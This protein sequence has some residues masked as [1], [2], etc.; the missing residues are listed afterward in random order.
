MHS[1]RS[2]RRARAPSP[3]WAPRSGRARSRS[4]PRCAKPSSRRTQAPARLSRRMGRES[5]SRTST[6]SRASA[7]RPSASAPSTAAISAPIQRRRGSFPTGAKSAAAAWARSSGSRAID[8]RHTCQTPLRYHQFAPMPKTKKAAPPMPPANT[9]QQVMSGFA[10][11][12]RAWI[13]A[14]SAKPET[15]LDLQGRYM[16]EQMKLWMKSFDPKSSGNGEET[17][18]KRFSGPE[19]NELPVFRYFRDSYLLTSKM[20]MTA[21]EDATLDPPTKQRMRFFMRQ[22]LDAAAPSNYLLTNPEAIKVAMET[23]GESLQEGM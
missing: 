10:D 14:V 23:K 12:Y 1:P 9:T 5:I 6:P 8:R 20:M 19:W 13:E 11:A 21:V 2:G 22:Y 16:Q 3:G 4:A 18:D 7:S 15:M 17:A